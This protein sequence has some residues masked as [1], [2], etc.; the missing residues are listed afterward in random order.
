[1]SKPE[2]TRVVIINSE[3][4]ATITRTTIPVGV[5]PFKKRGRKKK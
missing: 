4:K 3:G 5:F 2:I 1:V